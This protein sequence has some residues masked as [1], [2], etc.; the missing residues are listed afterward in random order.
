MTCEHCL[1]A[2]TNA[3]KEVD[4]SA[5]IQI[6]LG[7]HTVSVGSRLDGQELL[8]IIEKAGYTPELA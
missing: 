2:I 5:E 1:N 3:I 7:S 4:E 8:Q 6:D